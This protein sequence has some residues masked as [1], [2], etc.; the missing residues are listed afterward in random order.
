M[1]LVQRVPDPLER[2]SRPLLNQGPESEVMSY[3][4]HEWRQHYAHLVQVLQQAKVISVGAVEHYLG[5]PIEPAEAGSNH[6]WEV[7]EAFGLIDL[8]MPLLEAVQ[9]PGMQPMPLTS[10]VK[11][12]TCADPGARRRLSCFELLFFGFVGSTW[13]TKVTSTGAPSV[14][15]PARQGQHLLRRLGEARHGHRMR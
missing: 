13:F 1:N 2:T 7:A 6:A 3:P 4:L 12:G 8:P 14:L 9:G 11:S 15:S 5:G 10:K